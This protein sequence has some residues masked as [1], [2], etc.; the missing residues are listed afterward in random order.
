MK[1][2]Y[3]FFMS[4]KIKP[5]IFALFAIVYDELLLHFWVPGEFVPL[6]FLTVFLFAI[7]LGAFISF[8][9]SIFK[10]TS[11]NRILVI[12]LT[13]IYGV[14]TVAEFLIQNAF[15]NFMSLSSIFIGFG[16]ALVALASPYALSE[17]LNCVGS[18]P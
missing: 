15:K 1:K 12:V 2:A 18:N 13:S 17:L 8:I 3:D 4:T 16:E 7:S 10:K 5:W 14:L 9:C 6:R 11:V